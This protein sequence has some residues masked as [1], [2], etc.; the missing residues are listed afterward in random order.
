ME[1]DL[2]SGASTD[3]AVGLV[4]NPV[5]TTRSDP[6]ASP[7]ALGESAGVELARARGMTALFG[8]HG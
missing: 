7:L 3:A 4:H 5:Y 2:F 6:I 8:L 1:S